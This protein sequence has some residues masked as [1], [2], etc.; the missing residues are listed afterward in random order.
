MKCSLTLSQRIAS[1]GKAE[2]IVR[3]YAGRLCDQQAHTGIRVLAS[4][5]QDGA[6]RIPKRNVTPEVAELIHQQQE[7]DALCS[8]IYDAYARAYGQITPKWLHSTIAAFHGQKSKE[9]HPLADYILH[10]AERTDI[11]PNTAKRYHTIAAEVC[12]FRQLTL[13]QATTEDM[14]AFADYMR[15]RGHCANTI[16]SRLKSLRAVFNRAVVDGLV[17]QNPFARMKIAAERYGSITYLTAE[18]RDALYRAPMPT[19][20]LAQQRD[21]FVFQCWTGCRVSDLYN[22]K[23]WNVTPDGCLQ[24]IQRKLRRSAPTTVRVPLSPVARE[25]LD[26]YKQHRQLLPF[27]SDQKY[28]EA[29]KRVIAVSGI[30]RDVIVQDPRTLQSRSVRLSKIASSHLARRTFAEIAF[31][32]T[33]SERVVSSMTGHSPRST[34]FR[35]YTEVDDRMKRAA[36]GIEKSPEKS[37]T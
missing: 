28:N 6:L 11:A 30:D 35:R 37:P 16:S 15:E 17:S 7:L 3:F 8:Y 5:W 36:L 2:V 34:A 13:E 1:D 29:I 18:E 26:R 32:E 33:G 4:A 9:M 25:I 14:Q 23:A 21:I 12:Q 27:V 20:A 19:V 24:Y 10:Y 31:A 22:L